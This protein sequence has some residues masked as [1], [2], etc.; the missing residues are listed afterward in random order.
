[1]KIYAVRVTCDDA[2]GY[3][4]EIVEFCATKEVAK[5]VIEEQKED[6]GEFGNELYIE[7]IYV[8]EE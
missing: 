6:Y 4:D 7:E 2:F 3:D 8:R 1:M 5:K